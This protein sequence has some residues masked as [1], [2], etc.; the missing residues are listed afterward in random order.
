MLRESG[1]FGMGAPGLTGNAFWSALV[2][3]RWRTAAA[4]PGVHSGAAWQVCHIEELALG[5]GPPA[6]LVD[7][8]ND[9]VSRPP[10]QHDTS[11]RCPFRS[12]SGSGVSI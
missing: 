6:V 8:K 12:G 11:D 2:G 7:S 10:V 5:E 4:G 1:T 9:V 3:M